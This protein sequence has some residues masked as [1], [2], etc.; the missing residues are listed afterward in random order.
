LRTE[1][2]GFK[3]GLRLQGVPFLVIAPQRG[4]Q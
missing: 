2:S 4:N 3:I 1:P